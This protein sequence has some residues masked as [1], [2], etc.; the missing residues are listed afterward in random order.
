MLVVRRS[1]KVIDLHDKFMVYVVD[2]FSNHTLFHKS[3]KEA[4]EVF[5]NKTVVGCSTAE[6]LSAYCD[7]ILKKGS[8]EKLSDKAIEETLD[9]VVKFLAYISDKDL[10]AEFYSA[11]DDH[12]RLILSK[13]KQQCGGQFTSKIEG[14]I[15]NMP[16]RTKASAMPIVPTLK[17]TICENVCWKELGLLVFVRIAFLGLQITKDAINLASC[18]TQRLGSE[19]T[20][21]KFPALSLSIISIE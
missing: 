10:F 15:A 4:F 17:V 6:L 1:R 7:N 14:M 21:R 8:S 20:L 18:M 16:R 13:L 12:E 9:K 19:L 5:C 11:N 3:L 2:C